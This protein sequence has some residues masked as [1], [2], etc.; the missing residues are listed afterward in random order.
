MSGTS[1]CADRGVSVSRGPYGGG[2]PLGLRYF[3]RLA[4]GAPQRVTGQVTVSEQS[5]TVHVMLKRFLYLNTTALNDYLSALE[6]G[7]RAD[8][9]RRHLGAGKGEG[10]VDLKVVRGGGERR[11][12]DEES[13]TL[14]DTPESQFERLVQLAQ[15]DPERSGWVDVLDPD[16][17]LA[18]TGIGAMICTE[19]DVYIPEIVRAF[20]ASGGLVEALD[21][22]ENLMPFAAALGLDTHSDLPSKHERDAIR[23]FSSKL[24]GNLV[25]VGEYDMSPWKV[26]GE[27][28]SVHLRDDIEGV[29]V[30]VGKVSKR[31]SPGQW[32]PVMA[33]PGSSLLP[34]AQRREM[35]RSK[36]NEGEEAN[37][38]EGPAV[39]LHVLAIYQ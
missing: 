39:M 20:S 29:A 12:E 1:R 11:Y 4:T 2:A 18:S 10:S 6:G 17:Q 15:Q 9:T 28:D 21:T 23:G 30:I 8:L 35:E 5:S 7:T 19:C 34:R 13:L 14:T 3:C 22:V 33:L 37:Y 16:T 38:V 31:W 27:V 24:G 36:P 26:V 32:K 25:A